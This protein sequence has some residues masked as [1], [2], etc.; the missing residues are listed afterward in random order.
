MDIRLT[1]K[2]VIIDDSETGLSCVMPAKKFRR[3]VLAGERIYM[4]RF[5]IPKYIHIAQEEVSDIIEMI[6][7]LM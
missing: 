7:E 4:A 2:E 6:D 3:K 1:D 5:P